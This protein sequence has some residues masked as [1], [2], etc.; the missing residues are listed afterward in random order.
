MKTMKT[1]ASSWLL[2][3]PQETGLAEKGQ[4]SWPVHKTS[5]ELRTLYNSATW[6]SVAGVMR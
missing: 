1:K 2:S 4:E 3:L 5:A 6:R